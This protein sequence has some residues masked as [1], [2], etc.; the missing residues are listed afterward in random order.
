MP[1]L[2]IEIGCEELP[3][4]AC[5]EAIAQAPGL[6]GDALGALHLSGGDPVAWVAPRRIAVFVSDVP[7]RQSGEAMAVRGP[8]ATAAFGEDGAPTKASEGFARGQGVAVADLVTRPDAES[9]RDFVW[10][11]RPGE[12]SALVDL[13]PEI[14]RR[15]LEGLRFGKTM[16]WGDGKGLRFSRPVRWITAKVGSE[17]CTFDVAGVPAS[18]VTRGHRFL[19]APWRCP[20]PG[21]TL[22]NCGAPR[23]LPT[24]W[25]G[26]PPSPMGWMPLL[27]R[28]GARGA[29]RRT[30]L[31]RS[32]T[33]WSGRA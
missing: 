4:S 7:A 20:R 25:S 15:V 21:H 11:D 14:A 33:S 2:L 13:V 17:T 31:R 10:F 27:L 30:S 24:T 19:G 9:G 8:A 18:G 16:R 3:S 12:D 23:F 6:M 26:A 22:I 29:T 32:C 5:R 1:D 28:R